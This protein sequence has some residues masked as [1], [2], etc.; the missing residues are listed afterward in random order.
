MINTPNPAMS[1]G[2]ESFES[3]TCET[4][5]LGATAVSTYQLTLQ[6]KVALF[7]SLFQGREDAYCASAHGTPSR[8]TSHL[9]FCLVSVSL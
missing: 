9:P 3:K 7:Q 2:H 8:L 4:N 1:F 6:D 5:H